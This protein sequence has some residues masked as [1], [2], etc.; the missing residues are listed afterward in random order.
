M[1]KFRTLISVLTVSASIALTSAMPAFADSTQNFNHSSAV[2]TKE[3]IIIDNSKISENNFKNVK[4]NNPM[5][6]QYFCADPTSV[7]YNGRLYVFGTNDHQQYEKNSPESDGGYEHIKSLTILSTDD[8]VNWTYHG[9]INVGEIAPWI[10]NS[11]APTVVSRVED[12]G[13]THFYLYFSN[14]GCGVGVLHATDPCGPWDDPL[15]K[16][17]ISV[18]TPGL[19]DCPNPFDPGAVIDENGVGWLSFGAGV[20]SDGSDYM[21]G[22]NRIVRLG[23]DM[24]SF[25]S[26]F[27]E[28]PAPYH[29]EASE[30][31]YIN[32]TYVYTYNTNWSDHSERWDYDCPVPGG[33]SMVYMTSKTPLDPKS[34]VMRGEYF[35]NPGESGFS[36][37]NNHTHLQKFK[38]NYYI[39]YHTI[40]LNKYMGVK[41]S[42]RNLNVDKIDVDE[43]TLT[44][45]KIGGTKIGV[46]SAENVNPF[47]VNPAVDL[48]NTADMSYDLTDSHRPMVKSNG[49]G[50]WIGIR[51]VEF[52]PQKSSE[53]VMEETAI[54]SID[55]NIIVESVDKPTTVFMH[56]S[57]NKGVECTGSVDVSGTG[58][59]TIPCDVGG[60]EGMNIM[61][62]FDVSNDAIITFQLDSLTVNDKYVIDISRE[63]TNEREWSNGLANIWNGFKD[64][65]KVY[66]SQYADFRFVENDN[67][68]KLYTA[69]G[70]DDI[71]VGNAD[72]LETPL[73]F[74]GNVKGTGR[75]EVRLDQ[76][77][78]DLLTSIDFDSPEKFQTVYND[79]VAKV[80][81]TRDLYFIYSD[82]DITLDSWGFVA[83]NGE[84]DVLWGDANCDGTVTLADSTAILQSIANPDK[85][86]LS[87]QG[88]INADIIDNGGGISTADAVAIKGIY[89]NLI[90]QS[91]L[92]MTVADYNKL[93][94]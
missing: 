83:E 11:W 29:L 92:P 93:V 85:Y 60:A 27:A 35:K 26:E 17:L 90:Q 36:Y 76:P 44:I 89:A 75:I 84:N 13:K 2:E 31:N 73:K 52:S 37:S 21:P 40:F 62:F 4:H 32:G 24:I 47:A 53:I 49:T 70:I 78:G 5:S 54:E 9:A 51:N 91:Q 16:P 61:G 39:F 82:K 15:G 58:K 45:T 41:G 74:Y 86:S 72:L 3:G 46:D 65:E 87:A 64:N 59:Y 80:G 30:L 88:A 20:A 8:M 81:G 14:N 77:T 1:K 94:K 66:Y 6:S 68:I 12:D 22:S 56:P 63:L 42:Y 7:E 57:T 10:I 23:E 18:D 55:Y 34:W 48:Y 67:A 38:D 19:T 25:D 33:C 43:E 79:E 69:K 50:S 71:N 28:I